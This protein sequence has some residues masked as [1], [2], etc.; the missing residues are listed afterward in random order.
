MDGS[1]TLPTQSRSPF[2]IRSSVSPKLVPGICASVNPSISSVTV[3]VSIVPFS[4]G[5]VKGTEMFVTGGGGGP[6][7]REA[8]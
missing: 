6:V 3:S 1:G 4:A 5:D 8:E 2:T 7:D